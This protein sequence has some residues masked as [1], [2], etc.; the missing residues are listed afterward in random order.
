MLW[1]LFVFICVVSS[2]FVCVCVYI[3]IHIC[4]VYMG[5]YWEYILSLATGW[6]WRHGAAATLPLLGYW[7]Q[8][9][10]PVSLLVC[11]MEGIFKHKMTRFLLKKI[12]FCCTTT[13][14][15]LGDLAFCIAKGLLYATL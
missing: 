15:A 14:S 4:I 1:F 6:T 12:W 2:V 13:H 11:D 7:I 5:A 10:L 9:L 3:Y 8:Q